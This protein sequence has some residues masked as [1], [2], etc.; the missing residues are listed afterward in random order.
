MTNNTELFLSKIDQ[1][2]KSEILC[3]IA[4]H[5]GISEQ[6]AFDEVV[7]DEA[8]HLLDYMTGNQ[9]AAAS[10]LMKRHNIS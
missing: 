8:E 6:E 7:D 5:Y 1:A 3:S 9:R 4:N 10:L 2:T